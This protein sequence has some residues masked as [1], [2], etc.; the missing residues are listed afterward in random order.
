VFISE[1]LEALRRENREKLRDAI[2]EKETKIADAQAEAEKELGELESQK[3][4]NAVEQQLA[5]FKE[6]QDERLR[7]ARFQ[8]AL[9]E[10]RASLAPF[11]AASLYQPSSSGP[12]ETN[13][14]AP[15]SWS[16]L[17]SSGALEATET[18]LAILTMTIT[19]AKD[20]PK[21]GWEGTPPKTHLLR[22]QELLKEFGPQLAAKGMLSE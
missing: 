21:H 19:Y 15:V 10:I 18:G 11:F 8:A 17:Q 20:R 4:I 7:E 6:E 5:Q 22:A 14:K 9:P 12:V 3:I 16:A 13:K 1:E 2:A